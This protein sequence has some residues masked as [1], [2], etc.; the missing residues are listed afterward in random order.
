ML[1]DLIVATSTD[2]SDDE[3]VAV[4]EASGVGFRRGPLD[5]VLERFGIVV[6][7]FQPETVVRLTA[8]CPVADV[9]II[10][11]VIRKHISR[12]VSYTSNVLE[13][14]FPDGL[15]VECIRRDAFDALRAQD[16]TAAEREHVTLG[17]YSH[18]E[19]YSLESVTQ[20]PNLNSLRWTVD[21]Q[22]DLDFIRTIFSNLYDDNHAF[23]QAEILKFL[24]QKPALSRTDVD[25]ARN[26]GSLK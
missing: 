9:A 10:D 13:P 15:D 2:S 12:G 6:D 20:K 8:D 23:G 22:E 25:D 21:V 1:D 11:D 4:L 14:T 26:A 7:E 24:E 19:L 3:L 16:L 17:I 18:P 5:D